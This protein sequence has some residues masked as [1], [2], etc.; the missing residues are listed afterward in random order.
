MLFLIWIWSFSLP[1]SSSCGWCGFFLDI[2]RQEIRHNIQH[3]SP[4]LLSIL[5]HLDWP[6]T[7]A[8][9]LDLTLI[10]SCKYL[11]CL[12]KWLRVVVGGMCLWSTQVWRSLCSLCW[13]FD[14]SPLLPSVTD[15]WN[16]RCLLNTCSCIV[17]M[18]RDGSLLHCCLM[19]QRGGVTDIFEMPWT[20]ITVF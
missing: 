7:T 15:W 14:L 9:G 10:S 12:G 5:H 11:L 18:L 13:R 8:Y 6:V 20:S 1:S 17:Y 16:R 4:P 2:T 19:M 3:V